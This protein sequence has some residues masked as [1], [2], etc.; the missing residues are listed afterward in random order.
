M[1]NVIKPHRRIERLGSNKLI[2]RIS[3]LKV[4]FKRLENFDVTTSHGRIMI[5]KIVY[6]LQ[7]FG[8]DFGYSFSWF[9]HGPYS[10]RLMADAFELDKMWD[11]VQERQLDDEEE[12]ALEKL[13][14]FLGDKKDDYVWLELLGSIHFLKTIAPT[15]EKE[16]IMRQ[17]LRHQGYFTEE[18]CNEAWNYLTKFD[19]R[20]NRFQ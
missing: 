20:E 14:V 18:M 6:F 3:I 16:E 4:I 17:V 8:V 9:I 19:G 1:E 15:V 7:T 11:T 2:E 5:Q 10:T 12:K 13:L